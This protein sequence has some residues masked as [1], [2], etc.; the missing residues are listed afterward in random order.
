MSSSPCSQS[1]MTKD[2]NSSFT[3]INTSITQAQTENGRFAF[4]SRRA[5]KPDAALLAQPNATLDS[6]FDLSD[7]VSTTR[8]D[9]LYRAAALYAK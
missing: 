5:K 4:G 3:S 2:L 1:S 6:I 9:Q 7:D 8:A